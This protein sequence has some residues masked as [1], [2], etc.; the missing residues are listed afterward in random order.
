MAQF[1]DFNQKIIEEFRANGGTVTSAPFGRTLVLVHHRG[2][3]SGKPR[4][5]PVMHVRQD[6]DTWLIAASKAG[7]P[8]HPA[9]YHNLMAHPQTKIET[10]DDGVVDV[11][12]EELSGTHRD[13]AWEKFKAASEGFAEYET[14]TARTIP[15]L[16]LRRA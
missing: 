6:A 7:A 12:V 15:V 11:V 2:A 8:N 9:W 3:K 14:R 13:E 5:N 16:A 1:N 10:P 4:I